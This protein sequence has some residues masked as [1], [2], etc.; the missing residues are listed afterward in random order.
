MTS[1]ETHR[2]NPLDLSKGP[3][4]ALVPALGR[5]QLILVGLLLAAVQG[6]DLAELRLGNLV[7]VE[8]H[9][10]H[11]EGV[12]LLTIGQGVVGVV[13]EHPAGADVHTAVARARLTLAVGGDHLACEFV[14]DGLGG[15]GGGRLDVQDSLIGDH[16]SNLHF[17][18][19]MLST[20]TC[21]GLVDNIRV[22][23]KKATEHRTRNHGI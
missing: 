18:V 23:N 7:A 11:A 19:T 13:A 17:V 15:R 21:F 3:P 2:H 12:G 8:R 10:V 20:N 1:C 16:G 14:D 22:V 6:S 5:R 4:S 9:V